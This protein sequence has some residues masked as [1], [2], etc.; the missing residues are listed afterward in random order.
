MIG[1]RNITLIAKAEWEY[2][3]SSKLLTGCAVLFTLLVVLSGVL[4]S[5]RVMHEAHEREH[6][7]SQAENTFLE[8][9]DRHPHRMVHYGHYLFRTPA[10]L[11][12]IDPGLDAV[13]GQA[14]F[15]EGHRQ[16]TAMFA[17]A[18]SS[19]DTAG[20][21]G[22][23]PAAVYQLFAP[24]VVILLGF[25]C[26]AREREAGVLS[27]LLAIGV[28]GTELLLGKLTALL[29]AVVVLL[30]PLMVT[31]VVSLAISGMLSSEWIAIGLMALVYFFYL[32]IW[33]VLTL[34][35]SCWTRKRTT[36]LASLIAAW[37]TITL[38]LPQVAVNVATL[39]AP[40][41]GKIETDFQ[42]AQALKKLGDGHNANDPAFRKLRN[43]LLEKYKVQR[44]EDLPVNFRGLV[45]MQGEEKLTHAMNSFAQKQLAQE[46]YAASVIAL[47]GWLTPALAVAQASRAIAGSDLSQFHRFLQEAE[48][49][50]YRFVQSLNRAH[51]ENLSYA[52]DI[53][54]NKN[55]AAAQKARVDASNWRV[56][57]SYA[58]TP[59]PIATRLANA[60]L[61]V[62]MLFVWFILAAG[63][64]GLSARRLQA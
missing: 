55:A 27:S 48:G 44:V 3:L 30:L 12:F 11:A 34:I 39:K 58:F 21:A 31:G 20:L 1:M 10:A 23:A 51:A 49:V 45:A 33:S 57:E 52:D 53:N 22:L 4:S 28:S 35:A 56:L 6:Q 62:V 59:A 64:L 8:Q 15:L 19:A 40:S 54:R 42:M 32:G 50:R 14:I 36:A 61:S 18:G 29:A 43:E 41:A 60:A 47:H 17:N 9:P 13:T 24:L 46:Q 38:V 16:N 26:V 25:T 2:W 37:I 7:Q 5:T 63:V